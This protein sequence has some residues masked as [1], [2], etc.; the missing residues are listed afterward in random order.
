MVTQVAAADQTQNVTGIIF[1]QWLGYRLDSGIL[2]GKQFTPIEYRFSLVPQ[3]A[4]ELLSSCKK[5]NNHAV[6]ASGPAEEPCLMSVQ[7]TGQSSRKR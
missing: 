5:L 2:G 4:T 6:L 1:S 3:E 7:E